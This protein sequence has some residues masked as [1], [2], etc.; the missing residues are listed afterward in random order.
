MITITNAMG[1]SRALDAM[2]MYGVTAGVSDW[3]FGNNVY[4]ADGAYTISVQVGNE[5]TVFKSVMV[6]SEATMAPMPMPTTPMPM[7]A[8]TPVTAL[9]SAPPQ[10]GGG[11]EAAVIRRLGDG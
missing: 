6:M 5:Q 9:P 10:T 8:P 4:L 3:H 7:V 1:M 2:A 11:S